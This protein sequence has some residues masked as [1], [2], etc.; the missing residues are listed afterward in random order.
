MATRARIGIQLPDGQDQ[1]GI[2]ALGWIPRLLG[3]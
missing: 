1:G 3:L 2:S